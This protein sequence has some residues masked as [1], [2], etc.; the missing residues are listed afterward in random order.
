VTEKLQK[1]LARAGIGSRR[2][3]ERWI[4]E[5]RISVDGALATLGQ[6]VD[7]GQAI[8]ID[9]RPLSGGAVAGARQRTILYHKPDG[10]LCTRNDPAGRPTIFDRLPVLRNA[11][12]ITVGRLDFNTQ[13]LLLLTTDGELAN[14]LMHPSQE[15]EREYAVRVLGKVDKTMLE[16][17]EAGIGLE[18]GPARFDT[19]VDVGGE[20]A[21]HWYH[22]T[23][24]EGR[25]REVRRLWEAVGLTV[26]R[27]VRVRYG[28]ITL[29]RHMHAG[30]WRELDKEQTAALHEAAGLPPPARGPNTHKTRARPA[31]NAVE[32]RS[33]KHAPRADKVRTGA[34]SEPP[35]DGKKHAPKRTSRSKPPRS[36][37]G[38]KG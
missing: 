2:E 11:R 15:I 34:R 21:N 37:R 26:S 16:R 28:P 17:L 8:S 4:E 25:Q 20:G 14:R 19:I 27:L 9:G 5:G 7:P 10:E 6:R 24:K 22:V 12:W 35:R 29:P 31:R 33:S 3:M 1:V 36:P 23:L 13:G 38:R 30:H 32:R 18:D